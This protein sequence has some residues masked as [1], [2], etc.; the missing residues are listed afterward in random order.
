MI[1]TGWTGYTAGE[2]AT[3]T[4]RSPA[5]SVIRTGLVTAEKEDLAEEG[6]INKFI[7]IIFVFPK[8][9]HDRPDFCATIK[10]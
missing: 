1:R 5:T 8:S 9:L 3:S 7:P 10:I 2:A 4:V 6:M